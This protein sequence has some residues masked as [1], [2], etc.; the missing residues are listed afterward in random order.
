MVLHREGIGAPDATMMVPEG[1]EG[2]ALPDFYSSRLRFET[3]TRVS[4]RALDSMVGS[5]PAGSR[6]L[7]KVDVEGT[8]NEIFRYGQEFLAAF[9]PTIL[10]EVLHGVADPGELEQLLI[11]HG[12][13]F[14]LV[15]E[16]DLLP[17][18]RI[19]P[20]TRFR[21][22]LFTTQPPDEVASLVPARAAT[23]GSR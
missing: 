22:W 19:V 1:S 5:L 23:R 14:D 15:R 2:S 13:R 8:E 16:D 9:H 7:M 18:D 10:C 6:V 11:P 3:G 4:F 17:A 21:D 12:Y 20:H